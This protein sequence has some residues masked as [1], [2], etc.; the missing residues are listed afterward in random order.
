MPRKDGLRSDSA[1]CQSPLNFPTQK[2]LG[3]GERDPTDELHP[4]PG[5]ETYFGKIDHTMGGWV[6]M[7]L[8]GAPDGV[9]WEREGVQLDPPQLPLEVRLDLVGPPHGLQVQAP[10]WI[11]FTR[12]ITK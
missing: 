7:N 4:L 3:Q 8:R 2:R 10:P 12:G 9:E 5:G 11:P 1:R 6:M